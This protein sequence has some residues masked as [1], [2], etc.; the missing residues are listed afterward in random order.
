MHSMPLK[1]D[2]KCDILVV[3]GG[4]AGLTTAREIKRHEPALKVLVIEAKNRVGGR[5][6]TI[7]LKTA[8]NTTDKFDLGGMF[9]E[10]KY[11]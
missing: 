11:F 9:L 7:E 10:I 8:G 3:G 2:E 5:T 6:N 4:I 1:S